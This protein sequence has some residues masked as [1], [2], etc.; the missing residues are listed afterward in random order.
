MHPAKRPATY[1]DVLDAP[2]H[3]VAELLDQELFLQPRPAKPHLQT[4]SALGAQ[5]LMAF[6]LGRG[7]PGG[8]WILHEPELHLEGNVV[9]PDIAG[10]LR[11]EVP[12]LDTSVPY[13]EEKPHWVAEVLSPST[14]RLDRIRKLRLYH[15]AEVAFAW[16]V[17][18][19][20]QTL[21]VYEHHPAGYLLASTHEGDA[22][23]QAPPFAGY[24]L[25]LSSLWLR[26][27]DVSGP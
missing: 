26:P 3:V 4:A 24:D 18:P 13:F 12:S 23:I 8:W 11:T 7:G 14:E 17:H 20:H 5:L 2:E 10:W 1:Q 9:V 15:R 21:E 22:T 19:I 6:Q 16:L 27:V 25:D